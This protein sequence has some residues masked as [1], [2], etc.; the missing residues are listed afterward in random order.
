MYVYLVLFLV[1]H[2]GE[3]HKS[4]NREYSQLYIITGLT[5]QNTMNFRWTCQIHLI[6]F[7]ASLNLIQ[8]QK[9]LFG[10]GWKGGRRGRLK[11]GRGEV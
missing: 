1:D 5:N 6:Y 9:L 10:G 3:L 2:G 11:I 7:N 8:I 4:T